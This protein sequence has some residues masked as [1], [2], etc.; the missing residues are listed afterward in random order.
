[1]RLDGV[2]EV[3]GQLTKEN[4]TEGG[5][6]KVRLTVIVPSPPEVPL[7][8]PLQLEYLLF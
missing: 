7:T 5:V 8:D 2:L 3:A 4:V 1:M 6:H